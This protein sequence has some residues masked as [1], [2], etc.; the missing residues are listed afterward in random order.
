[1][2]GNGQSMVAEG[3]IPN[4]TLHIQGHELHIPVYLLP[5]SGV[6]LV[7]GSSWLATL[8]PHIADYASLSIKFFHEGRFITL[9]GAKSPLPEPAQFHNFIRLQ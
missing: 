1:M 6:D 9:Q 2:V 8:G 4:L 5:I 7:L 3:L